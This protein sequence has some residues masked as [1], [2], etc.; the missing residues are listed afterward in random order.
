MYEILFYEDVNGK[1]ETYDY[2]KKISQSNQKQDKAIYIKMRH[3]MHMLELLGP[4]LHS[5][6]AKK[7]KGLDISLWELRPMPER[8]FYGLWQGNKFILL[9]HYTKKQ[10]KTDP[11]ELRQAI[12]LLMD[13]YERN[14]R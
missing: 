4:M 13:W 12:T 11:R 6:Q 5:P 2:F 9:N 3:Q 1:S 8:V 7:I 10:D 14:G